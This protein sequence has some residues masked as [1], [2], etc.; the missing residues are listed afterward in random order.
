MY[1]KFFE[2]KSWG[3]RSAEGR[4]RFL[5]RLRREVIDMITCTE[6]FALGMLICAIISVV[7]DIIDHR[8]T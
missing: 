7:L 4:R 5:Q 1:F 8:K 2:L 6:L 3:K